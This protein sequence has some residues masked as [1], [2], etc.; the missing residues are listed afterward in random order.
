LHHVASRAGVR[1]GRDKGTGHGDATH[2]RDGGGGQPEAPATWQ[3][4]VDPSVASY[5]SIISHAV[6]R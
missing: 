6:K 4:G 1:G 3:A 2:Q 5:K